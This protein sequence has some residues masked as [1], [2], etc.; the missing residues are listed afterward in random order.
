M[1]GIE[2]ALEQNTG[3]FR[4]GQHLAR[5]TSEIPT[6]WRI[7]KGCEHLKCAGYVFLKNAIVT[8][9]HFV[10]FCP[11]SIKETHIKGNERI[12]ILI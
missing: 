2:Q 7:T 8:R 10:G 6:A 9:V 5:H 12:N 1:V 11:S 3:N 4:V